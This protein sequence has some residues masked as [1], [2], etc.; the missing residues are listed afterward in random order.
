[1]IEPIRAFT[2]PQY[3]RVVWV[4]GSQMGKTTGQFV[5]A[6]HKLDDNPAPV[7]YIGPTKSTV[8]NIIEPK[9]T[10]MIDTSAS[11]KAKLGAE[12]KNTKTKKYIGGISFRLAWAGSPSELAADSAALVMVDECDRMKSS[13]AKEGDPVEL[14]DARRGTYADGKL[15]IASTPTIG[16]IEV[17]KHPKTG[18]EHWKV[19]DEV[20]SRVWI[21]Y[22][23]GTRHQW[24][25][26]CLHCGEYFIPR[27]ELLKWPSKASPEVAEREARLACPNC[28]VLIETREKWRMN[29][30]GR[31]VSP[32]EGVEPLYIFNE[33]K[34]KVTKTKNPKAG[35]ITGKSETADCTAATFHISGICSFSPAKT[36]GFIAKKVV[37]AFRRHDPDVIQSVINT[38][39]GECYAVAG[40]AENWEIVRSRRLS[41]HSEQIPDGVRVL[42]CGVDVQKNRLVY[43]VRGWGADFESWLIK[44]GELPG[45]TS[46]PQVWLDLMRLLERDWGGYSIRAMGVDSGYNTTQVYDFCEKRPDVAFPTKGND[47]LKKEYD[48]TAA[49]KGSTL[50][51]FSFKTDPY[52]SWVQARF[53]WKLEDPGGWWVPSDIDEDYCRQLTSEKRVVKS[54]TGRVTWIVVRKNNHF[55]DCEVLNALAIK[56]LTKGNP[57]YFQEEIQSARQGRR[58][59]TKGV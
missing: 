34:S 32:G 11:L 45:E 1:M 2:I 54:T 41:Y 47:N 22:Q 35:T 25:W 59:I 6:G 5:V 38:E 28:G 36:F 27:L 37:S 31:F 40:K 17:E 20:S 24:A 8:I 14:A 9:V 7:L 19:S 18:L 44:W 13:A 55:F 4:M 3:D 52:K 26:P 39:L 10:S 46:Q 43:T 50:Q 30:L 53:S 33:T 58:V 49:R 42:T 29:D 12:K 57:E 16:N 21:L 23:L 48:F 15:G 56:V 51:L